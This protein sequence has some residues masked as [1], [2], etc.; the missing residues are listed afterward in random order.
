MTTTTQ[1]RK[2]R[3]RLTLMVAAAL[4]SSSAILS[5]TLA[6]F[7]AQHQQASRVALA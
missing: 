7:A 3:L 6:A 1:S 5:G 4:G 2:G